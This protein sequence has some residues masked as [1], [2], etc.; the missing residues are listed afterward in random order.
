MI[1]HLLM[2]LSSTP[3]SYG[4]CLAG[5][6]LLS[7]VLASPAL[8]EDCVKTFR[9]TEDPPYTYAS[10][11]APGGVS[12]IS[13][14]IVR[15]LLHDLGCEVRFVDMPWARALSALKTGRVD[16]VSGAFDTPERRA[17]AHYANQGDTSPNVIFVRAN[18]PG[19]VAWQQFSD[20]LDSDAALGGQIGVNYGPEYQQALANGD[21]EGRLTLVPNRPLLWQMLDRDRI[22]A[23]AASYLTGLMEI[24][25]LGYQ[26]R[27]VRTG[28]EL[29]SDPAYIIFSKASVDETF[30]ERFNEAHNTLL[31]SEDYQAIVDAHTREFQVPE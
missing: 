27:I 25:K 3:S 6:V 15:T 24:S 9:W 17:Y 2:T 4:R 30:V 10:A 5:C 18:N 31:Q 29:S 12:G 16:I 20:L 19:A 22:D 1:K 28:I 7:S 26:D 21:L 14:D 13:A 11:D 23:V 8:A